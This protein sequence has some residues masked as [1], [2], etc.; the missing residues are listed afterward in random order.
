MEITGL[1]QNL[2]F[3]FQ[4]NYNQL[5]GIGKKIQ[6]DVRGYDSV[7]YQ[8]DIKDAIHNSYLKIQNVIENGNLKHTTNLTGY[9][10]MCLK[11][12]IIDLHKKERKRTFENIND[13]QN[14]VEKSLQN[15]EESL[16]S[17]QE[18]LDE[19]RYLSKEIFQYLDKRY[20]DKTIH[21]FRIYF[22]TPKMTYRKCASLTGYSIAYISEAIKKI[23]KD[24]KENLQNYIRNNK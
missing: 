5:V 17:T 16:Q 23:K 18:Y 21:L 1:T 20:D 13:C 2:N 6:N 10:V 12:E 19:I 8:N 7:I 3:I 24:L 14:I 11:N 22:L 9:T 15:Q 4:N